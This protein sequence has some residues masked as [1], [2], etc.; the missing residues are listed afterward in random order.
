[1]CEDEIN[2]YPAFSLY[3]SVGSFPRKVCIGTYAHKIL[4]VISGSLGAPL[5]SLRDLLKVHGLPV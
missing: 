4:P 3:T 5:L 2:L 1:M